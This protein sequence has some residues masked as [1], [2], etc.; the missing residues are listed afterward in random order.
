MIAWQ[1]RRRDNQLQHRLTGQ[2]DHQDDP[3]AKIRIVA[4]TGVCVRGSACRIRT[5]ANSTV[6]CLYSAEVAAGAIDAPHLLQRR[7]SGGSSVP[8]AAQIKPVA[9]SPPPQSALGS[10]PVSFHRWPAVSVISPRHLKRSFETLVCRLELNQSAHHCRPMMMCWWR[11]GW[12]WVRLGLTS[13][14]KL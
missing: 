4:G 12:V 3:T 9:V 8:H 11:S 1:E 14:S 10:T 13:N 5:S 6:T 7:E 2:R